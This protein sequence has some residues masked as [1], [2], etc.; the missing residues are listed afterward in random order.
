MGKN[1]KFSF[2]TEFDFEQAQFFSLSVGTPAKLKSVIHYPLHFFSRFSSRKND[3]L[4]E[5]TSLKRK[6]KPFL[7]RTFKKENTNE[8]DSKIH[9]WKS[10][11]SNR[12]SLLPL[13]HFF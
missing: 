3:T 5:K 6:D 12:S 9:S 10:F 1:R 11:Q 8:P 13:L 7:K 4:S 2:I